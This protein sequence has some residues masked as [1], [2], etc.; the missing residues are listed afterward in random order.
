MEQVSWNDAQDFI[1]NREL[2]RQ[3]F[4]TAERG[5]VGVVAKSGGGKKRSTPEGATLIPVAWHYGNSGNSTHPVAQKHANGLGIYD[6]SGNVWEWCQDW[7]TDDY[8]ENSP[9][10]SPLGP[11]TK[12]NRVER[13]GS[14]FYLGKASR[15]VWRNCSRPGDRS[16]T[17]AFGWFFLQVSNSPSLKLRRTSPCLTEVIWIRRLSHCAGLSRAWESICR[18]LYLVKMLL[19]HKRTPA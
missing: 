7:Y 3:E 2:K 4:S 1:R 13:G 14:M 8:N 6:M 9:R 12:S 19:R 11:S 16:S 18:E 5:G 15:S 10:S 17:W